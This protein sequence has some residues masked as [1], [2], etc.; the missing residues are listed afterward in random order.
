M[1]KYWCAL[2]LT[3]LSLSGLWA[4]G[5]SAQLGAPTPTTRWVYEAFEKKTKIAKATA[6]PRVLIVA[7][8]SALFG[9]DSKALTQALGRPVI[10]MAV[11]A[12][13]GLRYILWRARR[14]ARSG[15][16]VLLP[17]EYALFVD[18]DRPNAQIVD[19]AIARDDVYWTSLPLERKL[20]F[21]AAVSPERWWQGLRHFED[22]PIAQGLYG[23][24]NIDS[25][26]DQMNTDPEDRD[27]REAEELA[28][29]KIWNYGERD[30]TSQGGWRELTSF[31]RWA[32]HSG[33]CLVA[34]PP[35]FLGR[36]IYAQAPVERRFYENLPDRVSR[37]G[38][39]YFGNPFDFMYPAE[40]FFNTDYHLQGWARSAHTQRVLQTPGLSAAVY[41]MPQGSLHRDDITQHAP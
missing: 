41:C 34:F 7:G 4:L 39:P 13:L 3:F 29:S 27:E 1:A 21:A 31:A 2:A 17:L 38:I 25:F 35:S 26:G 20:L 22:K 40:W 36:P 9:L 10:N 24:H 12:G 32:H 33:V 28:S 5:L 18:D 23:A 6:S 14:D 8:S 37:L 19:Y 15:D 11:N 16:T 30:I